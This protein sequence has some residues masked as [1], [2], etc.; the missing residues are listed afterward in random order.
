MT[1]FQRMLLFICMVGTGL[2]V[3]LLM[4]DEKMGS[5]RSTPKF[6]QDSASDDDVLR[7]TDGENREGDI[8]V[9]FPGE[10]LVGI[11]GPVEVEPGVFEQRELYRVRMERAGPDGG[12]FL[13]HNATIYLLDEITGEETGWLRADEARFELSGS[14]AGAATIDP[15]LIGADDFQL[16]GD[17]RG[18]FSME[19][20]S[21]VLLAASSLEVQGEHVSGPGLVKWT[22]ADMT[23]EGTDFTWDGT[24]GRVNYVRDAVI[25][26]DPTASHPGIDL[27]APA[28]LTWT[29]P[30]D[31]PDAQ[32]ESYGELRGRVS[33]VTG[34]G[35]RVG[36]DT[37]YVHAS[38]LQLHGASVYERR[39]NGDLER[40]TAQRISVR[41]DE[42]GVF[43]FAEA[44]GDV[45]VLSA[46]F[47]VVPSWMVSEQLALQDQE[48]T[49]PGNVVVTHD[50]LV[51]SGTDVSWD[52]SNGVLVY[53]KDAQLDVDA[54]SGRSIAGLRL[55]GPQGMTLIVPPGSADPTG[56]VKGE[57]RGRVEGSMSDGTTFA[58]DVLY[59]DGPENTLTLEGNSWIEQEHLEGQRRV[60]GQRITLTTDD[61]GDLALVTANGDVV[62]LSSP[63]D[64]LPTRIVASEVEATG[65]IATATGV[66][67]WTR[68]PLTVIGTDVTWNEAEGRLVCERDAVITMFDPARQL[69][70]E[71]HGT[72]GLTWSV[73]ADAI[74]PFEEGHGALTGQVTGRT[75]DGSLIEAETLLI[76]GPT[77]TVTLVGRS[78]VEWHGEGEPLRLDSV[79]GLVVE[80]FGGTQVKVRTDAP[81]TWKRGDVSGAGVGLLWDQ[82]SGRLDVDTDVEVVLHNA[83]RARQVQLLSDGSLTWLVGEASAGVGARLSSG[84]MRDHVRGVMSDGGRFHADLLDLDETTRRIRLAGAAHYERQASEGSIWLD[85]SRRIEIELEPGGGTRWLDADGDVD[86]WLWPTGEVGPDD[87]STHLTGDRVHLDRPGQLVTLTGIASVERRLAGRRDRVEATERIEIHTGTTDDVERIVAI[88]DVVCSGQKLQAFCQR[89]DW[90]LA[91]DLATLE[92][93]SR[94]LTAGGWLEAEYMRFRPEAEELEMRDTPFNDVE[95]QP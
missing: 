37:V 72:G 94:L 34:D 7:I 49:A 36:A 21:T 92:G 6:G 32:A 61:G 56:D 66:V 39:D 8:D 80:D 19:D 2:L 79:D 22:R 95:D 86:G 29:F 76:D 46:P 40:I 78:A 55:V 67:T 1:T 54:A 83:D 60:E 68:G 26:L 57:V 51:S 33:G 75:S 28:G 3:T 4:A 89:L 43:A 15:G 70:L 11:E 25:H 45:R 12:E 17:V 41:V 65:E 81:I 69:E 5:R 85:A 87:S 50:D 14:L 10:L 16:D 84:Q 93:A 52:K 48:V 77:K 18:E 9:S 44:D 88:R 74:S 42:Q 38:T 63:V 91:A 58:A 53:A 82:A 71:L 27:F 62:L 90:N 13:A 59:L 64:V 24:L 35:S 23:L 47:A 73:P 30:P 20:G 31:A